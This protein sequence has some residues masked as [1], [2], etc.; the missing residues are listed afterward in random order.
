MEGVLCRGGRRELGYLYGRVGALL[1]VVYPATATKA[2]G[3]VASTVWEWIDAASADGGVCDIDR[4]T[5]PARVTTEKHRTLV[6]PR[7]ARRL[8]R[9]VDALS[10]PTSGDATSDPTY[11]I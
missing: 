8:E 7:L 10:G 3:L 4:L 9:E 6:S 5:L 11:R 2:D 1:R